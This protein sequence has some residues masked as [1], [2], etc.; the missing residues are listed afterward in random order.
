MENILPDFTS[1]Q[2]DDYEAEASHWHVERSVVPPVTPP[3]W[4]HILPPRPKSVHS[5]VPVIEPQLPLPAPNER[6]IAPVYTSASP[7]PLSVTQRGQCEE[8]AL[9]LEQNGQLTQRSQRVAARGDGRRESKLNVWN[10]RTKGLP[11]FV[12]RKPM[13]TTWEDKEGGRGGKEWVGKVR[14]R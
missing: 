9:V 14:S 1:F 6:Y 3:R 10:M 13:Q 11:L 8:Y 5:H 4:Q 7:S 12:Q 2:V